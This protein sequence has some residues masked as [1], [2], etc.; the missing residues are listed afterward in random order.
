[1]STYSIIPNQPLGWSSTIPTDECGCENHK[2]CA[3]ILFTFDEGENKYVSDPISILYTDSVV[4]SESCDNMPYILAAAPDDNIT[5]SFTSYI[6]PEDVGY[7]EGTASWLV[8]VPEG[9]QPDVQVIDVVF[10]S[11]L[12]GDCPNTVCFTVEPD[13][14]VDYPWVINVGNSNGTF[15]IN[16]S[17]NPSD[18]FSI[19][20]EIDLFDP[21]LG[22]IQIAMDLAGSPSKIFQGIFRIASASTVCEFKPLGFVESEGGS[23]IGEIFDSTTTT[24]VNEES[25]DVFVTSRISVDSLS[26]IKDKCLYIKVGS[27]CCC[28][29][30]FYS[31][32]VKPIVDP[33][34]TVAIE[35]WQNI[36]EQD[37]SFGFG[38]FYPAAAPGSESKQFMR[39]WGEI[40][41]PQYDGELELYQDSFGRKSVVYSESREFRSFIVNYSPEYV[42]NALRLAC[43]HDNFVL[44]DTSYDINAVNFFTRSETYSPSWIRI[45]KLA[46]VTLEVEQQNQ[47]LVG[48]GAKTFCS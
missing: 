36:T 6:S 42:H 38:F 41:N 24:I 8:S 27:D 20:F 16:S 22:T 46:P 25:T 29:D 3:P 13:E 43:R 48:G 12:T 10:E 9:D 47:N 11:P 37:D 14:S 39:V 1:M 4:D 17:T 21:T 2:Y 32:C 34:H 35:F 31:K 28:D 15:E 18:G 45:S 19:C 26:Q 23:I 5:G 44:T 33:C 30:A 40:K 7:L